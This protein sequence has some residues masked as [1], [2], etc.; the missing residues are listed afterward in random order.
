[1]ECTQ[2]RFACPKWNHGVFYAHD[3]NCV[4]K[5]GFYISDYEYDMPYTHATQSNYIRDEHQY[6][7]GSREAGNPCWDPS[8]VVPGIHCASDY[9]EVKVSGG[10]NSYFDVDGKYATSVN[11]GFYKSGWCNINCE[12]F[13]PS[14]VGDRPRYDGVDE[15]SKNR[16]LS[17]AMH[18]LLDR[19]HKT[20]DWEYYLFNLIGWTPHIHAMLTLQNALWTHR[21]DYN[22]QC[23]VKNYRGWNEIPMSSDTMLKANTWGAS[24]I[25]LPLNVSKISDLS[26]DVQVKL[27]KKIDYYVDNHIINPGFDNI[28]KQPD[29]TL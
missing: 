18:A 8:K 12:K 1:M 10:T 24:C 16:F 9:E 6:G 19:W 20:D 22:S 15:W 26:Y 13:S 3:S 25:V 14:S 29:P 11:E 4:D 2:Q 27:A 28:K 21:S 5:R 17:L 23:E 7:S